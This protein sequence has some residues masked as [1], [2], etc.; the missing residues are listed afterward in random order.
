MLVKL[1]SSAV[2]YVG[3]KG[4][5]RTDRLAMSL[6]PGMIPG[7]YQHFALVEDE[8]DVWAIRDPEGLDLFSVH[9]LGEETPTGE[10]VTFEGVTDHV[11]Y[12][13]PERVNGRPLP[14]HVVMC[15]PGGTL[16]PY[17]S[18]DDVRARHGEVVIGHLWGR[19]ERV[20]YQRC[21]RC[22]DERWCRH[23]AGSRV[24]GLGGRDQCSACGSEIAG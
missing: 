21:A 22:R 16:R 20:G 5:P 15:E 23:P 7:M 13:L 3:P 10:C 14:R 17:E 12:M 8:P 4:G 2:H 18:V 6:G 9:G 19:G 24:R 11:G 1:P